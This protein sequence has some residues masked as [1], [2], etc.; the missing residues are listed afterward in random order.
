MARI[1]SKVSYTEHATLEARV[2]KLEASNEG[3]RA[4]FMARFDKFDTHL[5]KIKDDL[6]TQLAEYKDETYN[7][8][9]DAVRW[10][11]SMLVSFLVGGSGVV[12][13]I[14]V[15]HLIPR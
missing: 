10:T 6:T 12:G 13:L 5:T 9:T 15:F 1:D 4:E 14:E 8:R 3:L 2:I 7:R 11:I